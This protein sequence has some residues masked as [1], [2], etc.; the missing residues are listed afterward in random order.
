MYQ[1]RCPECGRVSYSAS[2]KGEWICPY[3]D[4]KA[5]ISNVKVEVAEERSENDGR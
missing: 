2:K 5:D 4:C 3:P 1:K